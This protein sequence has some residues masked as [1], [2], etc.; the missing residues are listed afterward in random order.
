MMLT[1]IM[2]TEYGQIVVS[3]ILGLGLATLFKQ[4]C[5]GDSCVVIKS[6]PLKEINKYYY[7]IEDDC[8][9]YTPYPTKCEGDK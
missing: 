3:I 8:F 5:K 2:N 6:P 9:K 1:E 4:V 7:K